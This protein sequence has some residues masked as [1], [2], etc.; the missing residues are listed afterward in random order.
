MRRTGNNDRSTLR[1]PA[2]LL[3]LCATFVPLHAADPIE[4]MPANTLAY[5]GWDGMDNL[6][7]KYAQTG[8]AKV[9]ADPAIAS[10]LDQGWKSLR[11]LALQNAGPELTDAIVTL[12]ETMYRKPGAI[13]LL[14]VEL[15]QQGPLPQ[16]V[17]CLDAADRTDGTL[18]KLDELCEMMDVATDNRIADGATSWRQVPLPDAPFPLLYGAVDGRVIIALGRSTARRITA[19]LRQQQPHLGSNPAFAAGRSATT[20]TITDSAFVNVPALIQRGLTVF[21]E[22]GQPLPPVVPVLL[23]KSGID[24]VRGISYSCALDG[25]GFRRVFRIGIEGGPKQLPAVQDADIA[26]IPKDT[27]FAAVTPFDLAMW[28]DLFMECVRAAMPDRLEQIDADLQQLDKRLGFRLREDFLASLGTQAIVYEEPAMRTLLPSLT[29]VLKPTDANKLNEC[30]HKIL[31]FV[32]AMIPEDSDWRLRVHRTTIDGMELS[33]AVV[34]GLPIPVAPAWAVH[35]GRL[36]MALHSASIE[37]AIYRQ[38]TEG[39]AGSLTANVDFRASRSKLPTPAHGVSYSNTPATVQSLYPTVAYFLQ[40]AASYLGG[41]N[42]EMQ[43]AMLPAPS[44]VAAHMFP[45]VGVELL[46]DDAYTAISYG[47]LPFSLSNVVLTTAAV[48]FVAGLTVP[49]INMTRRRAESVTTL[50]NARMLSIYCSMYADEHGGKFP[51][52]LDALVRTYPDDI[53]AEL[54]AGFSYVSGYRQTGR[55]DRI[56]IYQTDPDASGQV[57]VARLSGVT[58]RLPW[59]EVKRILAEQ[60][61]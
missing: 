45:D 51:R 33:H 44:A 31:R 30:M 49:T 59:D 37:E 10:I 38:K 35:D 54:I 24:R 56:F 29:V 43:T 55:G 34:S 2:T 5:W 7:P 27:N 42:P 46:S 3:L 21:S 22:M 36:Y 40:M 60:K 16:F 1:L 39:A 9:L 20:G 48:S 25:P 23:Q 47:P 8:L 41:A 17:V 18:A 12:L 15:G 19:H 6:Q 4:A 53:G 50:N 13:A 32:A 58:E 11:E 28:Y 57:V 61:N 14:D 26:Q 52:S